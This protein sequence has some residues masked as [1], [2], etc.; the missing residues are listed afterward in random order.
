MEFLLRLAQIHES[1]RIPELEALANLA[2]VELKIL[3]YSPYVRL[4]ACVLPI[5]DF[6]IFAV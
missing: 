3:Q 5:L 4:L 1:F 2:D 6:D